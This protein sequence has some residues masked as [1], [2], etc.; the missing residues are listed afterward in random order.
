MKLLSNLFGL[1]ILVMAIP[2]VAS[3]AKAQKTTTI[4]VTIDPRSV[5]CK[6]PGSTGGTY[7]SSSQIP[8]NRQDMGSLCVYTNKTQFWVYV[9][10]LNGGQLKT[11][12]SSYKFNYQ[13][14]AKD[15]SS[16]GGTFAPPFQPSTSTNPKLL[17]TS[18][19]LTGQDKCRKTGG[20]DIGV[21]WQIT[22][23]TPVP[24]GVY[25]DT[26][27]YTLTAN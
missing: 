19:K 7:M 4:A 10:S 24:A 5:F 26:I 15:I 23:T 6:V 11:A 3:V 12:S 13:I 25:T 14:N 2:L 18:P 17:Y 1:S 8:T 20:C 27:I 22:T 16:I 21:Q 9:Y